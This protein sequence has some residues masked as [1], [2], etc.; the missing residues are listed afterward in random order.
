MT[1]LVFPDNTVL[2]NFALISRMDLLE[3]LANGHGAW[4]GTVA[5]ECRTSAKIPVSR[6]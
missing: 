6:T 2:V 1:V 4:C 5:A 3:R